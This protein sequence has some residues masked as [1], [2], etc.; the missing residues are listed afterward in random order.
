LVSGLHPRDD[1][2]VAAWRFSSNGSRGDYSPHLHRTIA[3][4]ALH[5]LWSFDAP[6]EFYTPVCSGPP[7]PPE[8]WTTVPHRLP[9]VGEP[10][11]I[12]FENSI[13][14]TTSVESAHPKVRAGLCSF[15]IHELLCPCS[16]PTLDESTPACRSPPERGFPYPLRST[17]AVSH[18][19]GGFLLIEPCS[20]FQLLTLMGFHTLQSL[21][22]PRRSPA[23]ASYLSCTLRRPSLSGGSIPF[24]WF[25]PQRPKA[26]RTP[27][28]GTSPCDSSLRSKPG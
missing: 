11:G 17:R 25:T 15:H 28:Q 21:C 14:S 3:P 7:V 6:S 18:D 4:P 10:T 9:P 20:L 13:S 24:L 27:L 19:L 22:L 5:L 8:S 26:L 1:L 2:S 12:S 16:A 23:W